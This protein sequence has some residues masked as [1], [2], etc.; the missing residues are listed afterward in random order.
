MRRSIRIVWTFLPQTLFVAGLFAMF[1][2]NGTSPS[3]ASVTTSDGEAARASSCDN[4]GYVQNYSGTY[5]EIWTGPTTDFY[6]PYPPYPLVQSVGSCIAG[7][8]YASTT[9]V[10][11]QV[12]SSTLGNPF[13]YGTWSYCISGANVINISGCDYYGDAYITFDL[14]DLSWNYLG[15]STYESSYIGYD[16]YC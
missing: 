8:D 4:L 7:P 13:C 1:L 5:Y 14:W 11:V 9:Y 12:V 10:L 2:L 15:S 3:A 6:Q 16:Y